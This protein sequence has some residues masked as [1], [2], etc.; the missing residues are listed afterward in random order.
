MSLTDTVGMYNS[1]NAS[2]ASNMVYTYDQ[3]T[4]TTISASERDLLSF[5]IDGVEVKFKGKE[6]IRLKEMLE[7]FIRDEHPEDLL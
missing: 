5:E 3:N 7:K 4:W 6:I 1:T 2:N